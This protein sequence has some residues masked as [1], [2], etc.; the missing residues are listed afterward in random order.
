MISYDKNV[1]Q[2]FFLYNLTASIAN[3]FIYFDKI[4]IITMIQGVRGDRVV[5]PNPVLICF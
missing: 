4:D 5:D 3:N 2:I 1:S